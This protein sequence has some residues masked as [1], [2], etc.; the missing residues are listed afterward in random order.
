[1]SK[2]GDKISELSAAV[3]KNPEK[4]GDAFKQANAYLND[5]SPTL[6]I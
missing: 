4:I 3:A 2:A 6:Y 5:I 1:M